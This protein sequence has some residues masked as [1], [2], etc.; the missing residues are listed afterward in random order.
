M[1]SSD[2]CNLT[3]IGATEDNSGESKLIVEVND[4]GI[5]VLHGQL[6]IQRYCK[7]GVVSSGKRVGS[8]ATCGVGRDGDAWRDGVVES[9][10]REAT[11]RGQLSHNEAAESQLVQSQHVLRNLGHY[12]LNAV[13]CNR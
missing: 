2:L 4:I 12:Y 8:C 9:G 7:I 1:M 10:S 13:C 5:R 11:K 3:R 6:I